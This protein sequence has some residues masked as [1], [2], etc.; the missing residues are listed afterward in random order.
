MTMNSEPCRIRLFG[1]IDSNNAQ[2]AEK[3]IRAQMEEKGGT[4]LVLDARDLD[5]ISS[6]G[7]RIILHLRGTCPDMRIE[8]VKPDVYEVFEMTGIAQIIDIEKDYRTISIEGCE[9]IGEGANGKIYRIDGDNVVKVYKNA[10]A[11]TDILHEREVARLALILGIPTAIS[12]DVVRVQDSYGSV[13]EMLSAQSFSGILAADPSKLDW[14]VDEYVKLLKLIHGTVVP[15]G[16]LPDIQK[17][18]LMWVQTALPALPKE[19]GEKV[20]SLVLAVPRDPHMVHGDYHTKN[21]MLQSGEVLLIDMDTL[22]TGHPIFELGNIFNAFVGFYELD[23]EA[24]LDFQG[25]DFETGRRFWQKT[26]AAY[27]ETEDEGRLREVEDKA[28]VMGYTRLISRALRHGFDKTEQ[29][30]EAIAIWR[31]KLLEVLGKVDSL[32]F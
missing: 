5:Y 10:D 2:Q 21:L 12:Y 19:A 23:K 1:R 27:L 15:E 18:A 8:R 20:L 7:L 28:R 17:T 13:F 32:V 11:L 31:E 14:C 30:K 22:A 6:A 3:D 29:E 25:F 26:L 9:E 24:I 4:P 16:K